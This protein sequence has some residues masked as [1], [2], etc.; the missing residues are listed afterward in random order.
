MRSLYFRIVVTFAVALLVTTIAIFAISLY[1]L[2][3]INGAFYESLVALELEQAQRIYET[4]GPGRLSSYLAETDAELKGNRYLIDGNGRDVVT[5]QDWSATL[6]L[7]PDRWGGPPKRDGRFI[8][9]KQSRDGGY[10]L[11][12][13]TPAPVGMRKFGPIF[14]LVF[15]VI[16]LLGW[17]LS[18]GIVS[19]LRRVASTVDA[20]G[21][22]DLSARV[23]SKRKDEIGDVARSFNSMADRIETL[24]TAERRLLQDVSHELRSPLARL[25][26][27]VE[28]IRGSPDPE[29]GIA[30]LQRE[31]QR[32]S[33]LVG[34]LLD[35]TSA[36]GGVFTRRMMTVRIATLAQE[37]VDDC[38]LEAEARR[39]SITSAVSSTAT[40]KCEP[41]LVRRAIENVLR[42]AV[43]FAPPDTA[44]ETRV[45]DQSDRVVVSIRDYGSGVPPE[46]LERIFD[47]FYRVD[48]SRNSASGGAGL[49]LSIARRAV[50]LHHGEIVAENAS[51]GLRVR[52]TIPTVTPATQ[53]AKERADE[54]PIGAEANF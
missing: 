26:F 23:K 11:L 5:G 53:P 3:H 7:R 24:V 31:I 36:E 32:L 1:I 28:L 51:P 50:L 25:S 44:V 12:V 39:V 27:A 18:A 46:A 41:E 52:I 35:M 42:N 33:Q 9:V 6:S 54:H 45:E 30:R 8:L 20:F 17:A 22:G 13:I 40:V 21:R 34:T 37:I 19:P 10:R 2:I 14:L 16:A 49:G 48:D 38:R 29:R 43:R 4:Q 15:V 47:A